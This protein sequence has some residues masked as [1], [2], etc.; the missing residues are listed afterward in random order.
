M[1]I[2]GQG[3]SGWI[4]GCH[5]LCTFVAGEVEL[6]E[7]TSVKRVGDK[8]KSGELGTVQIGYHH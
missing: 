2:V 4:H 5:W 1:M 3:V 8:H 7:E 6:K